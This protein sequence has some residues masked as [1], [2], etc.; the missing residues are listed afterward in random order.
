MRILPSWR[1]Q[2]TRLAAAPMALTNRIG[3]QHATNL[4]ADWGRT[5]RRGFGSSP[6]V[7]HRAAGSDAGMLQSDP[8]FARMPL[9]LRARAGP[10]DGVGEG[11]PAGLKPAGGWFPEQKIWAGQE[12]SRRRATA[13]RDSPPATAPRRQERPRPEAWT[14]FWA[15]PAAE[16]ARLARGVGPRPKH[17]HVALPALAQQPWGRVR[18]ALASI[19][20]PCAT[21]RAPRLPQ[22]LFSAVHPCCRTPSG[23]CCSPTARGLSCRA[24]HRYRAVDTT[25]ISHP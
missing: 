10:A 17:G 14:P 7:H 23:A 8:S 19:D 20:I 21:L 6:V 2:N 12:G 9:G 4:S 11:G 16:P 18:R 25:M 24:I 13:G 22:R 3:Q 5:G 15:R 1:T